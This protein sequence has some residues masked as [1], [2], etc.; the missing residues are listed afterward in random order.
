MTKKQRLSVT[1]VLSCI[2]IH[3]HAYTYKGTHAQH[4]QSSEK[5]IETKNSKATPKQLFAYNHILLIT[6]VFQTLYKS[7][8]KC[9]LNLTTRCLCF[10]IRTGKAY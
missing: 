4:M 5:N 10:H 3:V 7:D 2:H 9:M 1:L 6:I 8:R